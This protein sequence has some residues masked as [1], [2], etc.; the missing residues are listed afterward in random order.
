MIGLIAG[1]TL[2]AGAAQGDMEKPDCRS[3]E[4][5]QPHQ[6]C[7]LPLDGLGPRAVVVHVSFEPWGDY[8]EYLNL[9]V[10]SA[11]GEVT[12]SARTVITVPPYPEVTDINGDGHDDLVI[13]VEGASAN[14][15]HEIFMGSADGLVE[16]AISANAAAIRPGGDGLVL[17]VSRDSAAVA[18]VQIARFID[19]AL[20]AEAA[21]ELSYDPDDFPTEDYDPAVSG[22]ACRLVYL[23]EAM[24]EDHYCAIARN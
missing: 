13:R 12:F 14:L 9:D 16:Q 7:W 11:P 10:R 8:R 21:V 5:A 3:L 17:L 18:I 23:G 15:E 24:G 4:A 20:R 2:L 22:P 19:G 6:D 1:L